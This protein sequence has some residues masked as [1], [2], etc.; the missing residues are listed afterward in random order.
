MPLRKGPDSMKYN[1][2][3]LTHGKVGARRR[4]G[5]ATFARNRGITVKQARAEQAW[6]IAKHKLKG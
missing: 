1:I 3:E 6:I 2:A 5:I 4:K